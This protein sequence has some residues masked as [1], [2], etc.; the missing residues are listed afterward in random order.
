MAITVP[1]NRN[2]DPAY[3]IAEEI[4]PLIRRV[5]AKNP[6]P[7]TFT[8]T[9]TYLIGREAVAVIDPGPD[10][11][12]HVS[13]LMAALEGR[14]VSHILIT[15]THRDHSPASRALKA[16]TGAPIYAFGPH[17]SG[18]DDDGD[19]LE[20]GADRDFV[21]DVRLNHKDQV[22]GPEWTIEAV[23]TPGHTSNHLCFAL[24][25]E[26]A[27]FTGD[28]VMGWSTSMVSPPDGDMAAYMRSLRELMARDDAI[29]YPTHGPAILE[30][31]AYVAAL[32]AHREEREREILACV[33]EGLIT[34][35]Q[36]VER[37]YAAVPKGLHPAA[38]R[39][40][41]A[42]IIHLCE[43]GRLKTDGAPRANGRYRGR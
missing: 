27:L 23:H 43:T 33:A 26:R 30:P 36:M 10:M 17:G 21:F 13:A 34:I 35:P 3:G 38:A 7:F 29:Y 1:F 40:V 41:L 5:V 8:G 6:G 18:R 24:Q 25:E 15:H 11:A 32:I 14:R 12:S 28:H 16:A 19:P 2:F 22:R 39:S 4:S 31:Q 9:G 37:M 20:E 42:H